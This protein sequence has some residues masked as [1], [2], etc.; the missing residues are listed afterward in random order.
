MRN[1]PT[2]LAE[3]AT[4]I[5]FVVESL[6]SF[7]DGGTSVFAAWEVVNQFSG[8]LNWL[9]AEACCAIADYDIAMARRAV[10][11]WMS[12]GDQQQQRHHAEGFDVWCKV[13]RRLTAEG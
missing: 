13:A 5:N 1:C 9:D 8:E 6:G 2:A 12:T 10:E 11:S 3:K 4:L 7:E